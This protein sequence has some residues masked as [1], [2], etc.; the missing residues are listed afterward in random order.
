VTQRWLDQVEAL[1]RESLPAAVFRYVAEGARNEIT[2]RE[3]SAAWDAVRLAPWVLRDVRTVHTG[4]TLLGTD[5]AAPIGIAPMTLQR[6]ADPAGE[7]TMAAAA[8]R[9]GV[10]M[11][12]SSNAGS[13]FADV[14]ATG[15]HWWLQVYVAA[16]R[17]DSVPLLEAAAAAGAAAVVLTADTPVLGT[18]YQLPGGPGIWEVA[19]PSWIGAN[20]TSTTGVLPED[21]GKAMDLG[22]ADIGW[23]A[24]T[25]GLPVVVKGV[26]RPD[27][28]G[29]CVAAGASAVWISNHGGRQ[30]DQVM[31]TAHC[32]ETVRAA[33]GGSA[34][35]YVDGGIRSG[36]HALIAVALGADA[37]FVGRPLFHALA[38][39]GREG[40]DRAL[41]EYAEELSESM[42]LAGCARLE[43]T[44]GI[45]APGP[46]TGR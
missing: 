4:T 17:R 14:A 42:R 27:D 30:L 28:A 41:D 5:F 38:A 35:V 11:V 46:E 26:L 32:V 43:D 15:A 9:A 10:P 33:V 19:D 34:E 25:T 39:D 2:L 18:R 24:E 45:V 23:L 44:R 12:L 3:A 6:A 20:A 8:R 13:T 31:A 40:V 16:D 36:L 29:R 22:P 7:V 37:A 21:R 1:A